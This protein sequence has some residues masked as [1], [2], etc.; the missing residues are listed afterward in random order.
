M[1]RFLRS[2]GAVAFVLLL[3][4]NLPVPASAQ[5]R[6]PLPSVGAYA[7]VDAGTNAEPQ[8]QNKART[9]GRPPPRDRWIAMDKAKH[10]GGSALLTLS[11]QYVLVVK[12]GWTRDDA[13]PLSVGTA[14]SIGLAKELYDRYAGPT[15]F[16]STKDLVADALGI[17]LGVLVI[18][19]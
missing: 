14:A 1:Y 2:S 6:T 7:V 8:F 5:L 10:L 19:V 18:M 16:F 9:P 17:A 3:V 11:A 13:L 12:S 4:A 15:R